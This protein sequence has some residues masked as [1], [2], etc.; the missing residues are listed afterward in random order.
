[1]TDERPVGVP[2]DRLAVRLVLSD[3]ALD[4]KVAALC[5]MYTQVAPA[6]AILGPADFR[7]SNREESFIEAPA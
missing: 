4:Q 2:V 7:D 1:M 5:A 3:P 6:L